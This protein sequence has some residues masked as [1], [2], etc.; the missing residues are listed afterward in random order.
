[1]TPGKAIIFSLPVSIGSVRKEH[2][3]LVEWLNHKLAEAGTAIP[4]IKERTD[5]ARRCRDGLAFP[6]KSGA[7]LHQPRGA[8]KAIQVS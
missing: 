4:Q 3:L 5:L 2:V 7:N 8:G 1:V 6:G